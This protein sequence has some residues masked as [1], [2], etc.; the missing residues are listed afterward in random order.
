MTC[1][2]QD[3][4]A[5]PFFS[6]LVG[7]I[8]SGPVVAM[9][10]SQRQRIAPQK[11]CPKPYFLPSS[12]LGRTW[13]RQGGTEVDWSD[14]PERGKRSLSPLHNGINLNNY[15]LCRP[16]LEPFAGILRWRWA[17][18]SSMEVTA[19]RTALARLR[20]GSRGSRESNGRRQ[21]CRGPGSCERGKG[22]NR[23]CPSVR[24]CSRGDVIAM[25]TTLSYRRRK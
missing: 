10:R 7:Y 24:C 20:F 1:I 23:H 11:L 22:C 5:K 12:D 19:W 18:T 4:S 3:L 8:I 14:K 6:S 13:G 17:A 15:P 16:S 21:A 2:L 25:T 9:A